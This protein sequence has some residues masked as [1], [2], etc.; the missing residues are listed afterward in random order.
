M[1]AQLSSEDQSG[2]N[3]LANIMQG[4]TGQT[5]QQPGFRP[6]LQSS[7]FRPGFFLSGQYKTQ[8]Y[9]PQKIDRGVMQQ[10]RNRVAAAAD[11]QTVARAAVAEK[12][13]VEE[14][15]V[16]VLH[17]EEDFDNFLQQSSGT[18]VLVEFTT[19]WCGPC[20]MFAPVYTQLA[21]DYSGKARF[22]KI[23][24]R[25]NES[26]TRLADR[27]G[28]KSIPA[29]YLI[30]DGEVV[31]KEVGVRAELQLRSALNEHVP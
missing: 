25:E 5:M 2:I 14:G 18:P 29:F 21:V 10:Y 3:N 13:Q 6:G 28:V 16:G 31:A 26:T 1:Q 9:L 19:Q 15:Q 8:E 27:F 4:R 23:D 30:R 22:L 24:G 20:K 12:P 17:S 7:D 11:G